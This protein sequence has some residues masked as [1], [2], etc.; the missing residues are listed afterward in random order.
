[1]VAL[2]DL[3]GRQFHHWTVLRKLPEKDKWECRCKCGSVKAV[4]GGNLRTGKTKSCGCWDV[5]GENSQ[6]RRHARERHGEFYV[7][8]TSPWYGQASGIKARALENGIEFGFGSICECAFYLMKIAPPECPVFHVP[9]QRGTPGQF[10]PYAPSVDRK[11]NSKGYVRG[12]LQIISVKANTMKAHAT[13][14]E[15]ELFAE[16]VLAKVYE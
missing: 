9:F 6:S 8:R 7:P 4:H 12:N 13:Q 11:D 5:T 10:S 2:I 3:A 14:D 16:W 1:M 15:L